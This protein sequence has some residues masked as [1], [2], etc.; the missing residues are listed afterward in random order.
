MIEKWVGIV[1]NGCGYPGLSTLKLAVYQEGVN[2][3]NWYLVCW[4]KF[5][6]AKRYVNN[7]WVLVVRNGGGLLGLGAVKSAWSQEW[8]DEKTDFLPTDTH[9]RKL[10]IALTIIVGHGQKLSEAF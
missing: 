8:I 6:K 1:K 7:F 4:Y 10:K 9:F 2:E 5:K 3:I